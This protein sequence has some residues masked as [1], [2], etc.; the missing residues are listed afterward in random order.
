MSKA[1][2]HYS[3][4]TKKIIMS[5]AGLFLIT[6]LVVHLAINILILFDDSRELFNQAAHFMITNPLI[7]GFQ[8][9][10]FAGFI[11]HIILGFV[12]QLQNW[13]ARPTRYERKG[14]SET[15]YFSK[16]M[17]H[18][19]VIVLIFLGIHMA[20]FFF[21][22]KFGE[23][24]MI[25]YDSGDTYRDVGLLVIELFKDLG[26]VV[27]YIVSLLLLGFH[28]DHGFQSAF[29]SLGVYHK[30]YTPAIKMIGKF[31]TIVVTAGY[32]A[33]PVVLYFF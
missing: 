18:T 31:Y 29:Q 33:I 19:G 23:V 4:I 16:F 15:S 17:I 11:L 30:T 24:P 2:L 25:T 14:H 21:R 13:M 3:S 32:I 22:V 8:W 20:N 10:L 27:F 12:L 26:Y 9:V 7:Q 28:L 1:V 6:F 5:L